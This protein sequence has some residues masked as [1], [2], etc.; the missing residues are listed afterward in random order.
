MARVI[1]T[2]RVMPESLEQNIDEL[3]AKAEEVIVNNEGTI[4][5]TVFTPIAFGL[6]SIDITFNM[7]E[8]EGGTDTI[9]QKVSE[10]EGIENAEIISLSRALG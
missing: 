1:A 10:I 4:N 5:S 3:K 9:E 8:Q 6:K 7:T 2:L